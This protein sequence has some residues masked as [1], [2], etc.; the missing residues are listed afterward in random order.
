[1][2][3]EFKE[4]AVCFADNRQWSFNDSVK[5]YK[6]VSNMHGARLE[7]YSDV[8]DMP[9]F[10]L[11]T[12][13]QGGYIE[14]SELDTEDKY[15]R[16]VGVF[17]LLGL[18][19]YANYGLLNHF[20]DL[21]IEDCE[22]VHGC[23]DESECAVR[24]ITF[25]QLMAIGELKRLMN[26]RDKQSCTLTTEEETVLKSRAMASELSSQSKDDEWP[27]IGGRVEFNQAKGLY[28]V[29][30]RHENSVWL[31]SVITGTLVGALIGSLKKPK[32]KED[33]LIEELQTKLIKSS[34]V[35]SWM[36]ATDIL[37][38]KIEGLTY[39]GDL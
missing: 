25:D 36:L 24:K 22:A 33:L 27:K 17:G 3:I 7:G 35:D 14:A 30:A 21:Y 12:I 29:I 39:K 19:C 5:P 9:D 18:E 1:M 15:N 38:G 32:S 4:G 6:L 26:E 34:A 10:Q 37:K 20:G 8:V 16:A 28:T 11:N 23:T 31:K 2:G 13:K